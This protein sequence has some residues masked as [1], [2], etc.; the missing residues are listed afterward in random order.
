MFHKHPHILLLMIREMPQW[1]AV[2]FYKIVQFYIV[3][4]MTAVA[5]AGQCA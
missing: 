5:T 2:S 4:N 1:A 3:T